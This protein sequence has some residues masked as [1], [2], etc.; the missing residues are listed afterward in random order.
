MVEGIFLSKRVAPMSKEQLV[1]EIE[2]GLEEFEQLADQN[3]T[4]DPNLKHWDS[5][6]EVAGWDDVD[7]GDFCVRLEQELE[8]FKR[9]YEEQLRRKQEAQQQK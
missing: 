5:E 3:Q 4:V 1:E 9:D 7:T 6:W 8:R 2:D